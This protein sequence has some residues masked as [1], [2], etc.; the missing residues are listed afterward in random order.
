MV[1]D[2]SISLSTRQDSP[3]RTLIGRKHASRVCK[4]IRKASQSSSISCSMDLFWMTF[5]MF[6][7]LTIPA[8][9][10]F[11]RVIN[12]EGQKVN[13]YFT[14]KICICWANIYE[15]HID[16]GSNGEWKLWQIFSS[17]VQR[18]LT[19]PSTVRTLN[20]QNTSQHKVKLNTW[21]GITYWTF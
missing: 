12:K 15:V 21:F 20:R 3:N 9:D 16:Q 10:C 14:A 17:S 18:W 4:F 1:R 2:Y 11:Y 13:T 8:E 6:I 7:S 5:P 19:P